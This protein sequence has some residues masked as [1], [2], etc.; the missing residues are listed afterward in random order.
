METKHT[1]IRVIDFTEY[2][3]PRYISQG[4]KSGEEFYKSFLKPNF[5][6]ALNEGKILVVDL[7][8]TAG[9]ASSFLDEAFGNLIFEFSLATVKP[10]ID[11]IS[12]QEPDWKDMIFNN[13][14][15]D[16]E[17]RRLTDQQPKKTI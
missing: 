8:N 11:I 16:W 15:N 9:F 12:N 7:D 3:G 6:T 5:E 10:N 17:G 2:P 1:K 4:D 14:F 13:V